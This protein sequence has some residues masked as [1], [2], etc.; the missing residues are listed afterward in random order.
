MN[1]C[2]KCGKTDANLQCSRCKSTFF[3]SEDCM[4]K[5]WDI[6]KEHCKYKDA[7]NIVKLLLIRMYNNTKLESY[8][9]DFNILYKYI[10]KDKYLNDLLML[11]NKYTSNDE[12]Y[13]NEMY[14]KMLFHLK[15]II[16]K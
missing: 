5:F 12:I 8:K 13:K 9:N 10:N 4:N 7:R 1:I 3:C 14:K 15:L 2:T 16:S 11:A 6:H